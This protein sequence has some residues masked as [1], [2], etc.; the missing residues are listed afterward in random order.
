MKRRD[1]PDPTYVRFGLEYHYFQLVRPIPKGAG[2]ED[3]LQ[4]GQAS[5]SS[6]YYSDSFDWSCHGMYTRER[7]D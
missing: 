4:L 3:I 2:I 7:Y 5:R 6:S 1:V